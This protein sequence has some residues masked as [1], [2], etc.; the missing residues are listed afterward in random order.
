[1]TI[2]DSVLAVSESWKKRPESS[3]TRKVSKYPVLTVTC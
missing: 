1:M 3:R 2:T